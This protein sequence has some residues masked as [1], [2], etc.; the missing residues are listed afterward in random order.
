MLKAASYN[1]DQET[2]LNEKVDSVFQQG[3][4]DDDDQTSS[5]KFNFSLYKPKI[6][7]TFR[8]H[9]VL[10]YFSSNYDVENPGRSSAQNQRLPNLYLEQIPG[11]NLRKNCH[12]IFKD[13]KQTSRFTVTA[14]PHT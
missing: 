11:I 2:M 7:H 1:I 12:S 6:M 14:C 13:N 3:F 9:K 8:R 4:K 5:L 10:K